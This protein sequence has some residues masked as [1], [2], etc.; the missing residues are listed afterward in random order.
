M[1]TEREIQKIRATLN[2][3]YKDALLHVRQSTSPTNP[4]NPSFSPSAVQ[5]TNH[6]TFPNPPTMLQHPRKP[7]MKD[8][9]TQTEILDKS[10]SNS[11]SNSPSELPL[12]S[13][14]ILEITK[15]ATCM[16]DI[17]S[18]SNKMDTVS[19]TSSIVS[20]AFSTYFGH[21]LDTSAL[22]KTVRPNLLKTIPT[23]PMQTSRRNLNK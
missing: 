10:C 21:Q 4:S 8:A 20:N 18:R 2:L 7:V 3:S 13:Q 22:L 12:R 17:F 11:M 19:K 6:V 23:P 9:S 14:Q 5:A 16:L 1:K 15:I